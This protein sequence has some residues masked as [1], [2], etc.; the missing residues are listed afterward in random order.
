MKLRIMMEQ[1][2]RLRELQNQEEER[3][4]NEIIKNIK[5]IDDIKRE[6]ARKRKEKEDND[7]TCPICM[8]DLI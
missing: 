6:V 4:S 7:Q 2:D 3:K 8:D 1:E 5:M